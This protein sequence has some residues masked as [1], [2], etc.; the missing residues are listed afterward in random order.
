MKLEETWY[1]Q[2]VFEYGKVRYI[3]G[4]SVSQGIKKA[5]RIIP[6]INDGLASFHSGLNT[7][8]TV[9]ESISKGDIDPD[10]A[11]FINQFSILNYLLRKGVFDVE[12]NHND[13][14]SI[15]FFPSDFGGISLS[16]YFSHILKGF[17]HKLTLWISLFLTIRDEN[18]KL[19]VRIITINQFTKK[20]VGAFNLKRLVDDIYSLDIES[21]PSVE[22]KFKNVAEKYLNSEQ[23]TNPEIKNLFQ[24]TEVFNRDEIKKVLIK[25]KPM[26]P[27]LAHEIYRH[28]NVGIYQ[29]L[30]NKITNIQSLSEQ[31]QEYMEID[32]LT[33]IQDN[34]IKVVEILKRKL[35]IPDDWKL[36]D[37][38]KGQ[39]PTEISEQLRTQHYGQTLIGVTKPH[40][41]HQTWV[42]DIDK[43]K[44]DHISKSVLITLS[45]TYSNVTNAS[46]LRHGPFNVYYG[47]AIKEK[48]KKPN[49]EYYKTTSF[50]KSLQQLIMLLSWTQRLGCC[51]IQRLITDLI[52][53]KYTTVAD[54]YEDYDPLDWCAIN[55]GGN[56]I[57]RIRAIME[58]R[59]ALLNHQ[60]TVGS[61]IRQ[62]TNRLVSISKNGEDYTIHFQMLLI[63][64]IARIM[65][66]KHYGDLGVNQFGSVL[67]CSKCTK[68]VTEV[69]F[70]LEE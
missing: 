33:L 37:L 56:M 7:I 49:I 2:R 36:K 70:D 16:T 66:M 1:S 5:E 21:L 44:P 41:L 50:L 45:S 35:K 67:T 38:L 8:N 17:D 52:K 54:Q 13:M 34:T 64:N 46:C 59:S 40:S 28:S 14:I 18:K 60:P 24:R 20:T 68:K 31:V 65:K 61:H 4:V 47:S 30:I 6:D 69:I 23:V 26:Y 25:M 10:S 29:G 58:K 12:D 48:V 3:E 19:F 63:S 43:L 15:L 62:S 32:F 55:L 27:S 53:E 42:S 22:M 11:F 9:T 39:C 51:N 57:H